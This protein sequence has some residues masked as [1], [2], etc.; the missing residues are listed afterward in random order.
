MATLVLGAVGSA[1]GGPLGGAL[2][3]MLGQTL[4][5]G[6]FGSGR[7]G[8]RL[9]DL[10]VQASSYGAAI[11][12]IYGTMRAA[13]T[14]VW[15]TDIQERAADP[16][17]Y[18]Y[19]ANFAVALSSRRIK[20]VRRIWAE[21]SLLRAAEGDFKVR[22][23]FRLYPGTEDQPVDPLIA[24]IEGVDRAP[25]FRGLAVAVF[26]GLEL[27]TYGNRIPSLTFEIEGADEEITV[28]DLLDS[29]LR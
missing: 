12:K 13:G 26:E 4:D 23:D 20:G 7:R 17:G 29:T 10:S 18:S 6:F 11:P 22:T 2:G 1:V 28:G 19:S 15:S 14:I 3:A 27:A 16:G 21:G 5:Q 24:A 9:G 8:P 25:A